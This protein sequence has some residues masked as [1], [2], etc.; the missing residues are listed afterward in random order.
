MDGERQSEVHSD[1]ELSVH[2]S[3]DV[4][5][6]VEYETYDVDEEIQFR[7][8]VRLDE[9]SDEDCDADCDNRC[10]EF[11]EARM[12]KSLNSRGS[13][14]YEGGNIQVPTE[15]QEDVLQQCV[16]NESVVNSGRL[17]AHR[18]LSAPSE[19][20]SAPMHTWT[21]NRLLAPCRSNQSAPSR[22]INSP[23]PEEVLQELDSV[24]LLNGAS[25]VR[26]ERARPSS[27]RR[28][29]P[30]STGNTAV[31]K[32]GKI[33]SVTDET[34]QLR[35]ASQIPRISKNTRT[36]Q[37]LD[38]NHYRFQSD[39]GSTRNMNSG[40]CYGVENERT[41]RVC[42]QSASSQV[43]E[44]GQRYRRPVQP[45]LEEDIA[46]SDTL[47]TREFLGNTMHQSIRE[48][49][50]YRH[51]Y[52]GHEGDRSGDRDHLEEGCKSTLFE[53]VS[54]REIPS[55]K[56]VHL[57][58]ETDRSERLIHGSHFLESTSRL[59]FREI[60]CSGNEH[61]GHGVGE[62]RNWSRDE[63]TER[64]RPVSSYGLER[65]CS[66]FTVPNQENRRHVVVPLRHKEEIHSRYVP[67]VRLESY[68]GDSCL[69]TFL[70]KFSNMASY[71]RWGEED[72]LFHLRASLDGAAAQILWD[73]GS[74]TSVHG[75]IDL[76]RARFGNE[77]QAERFRAELKARRRRKGESLQAL[78]NEICRLLALAYP[79]P[80]S[81]IISLVG[82]DAFL[83]AL[84][85]PSLK[86]RILEKEPKTLEEALSLA[87]RL[88][89]Y[90]R[91][92]NTTET[93]EIEAEYQHRRNR[94]VRTVAAT[95]PSTSTS[96]TELA[97]RDLTK[98]MSDL[99][100]VF[101]NTGLST[102]NN[103]IKPIPEVLSP[104]IGRT[105]APGNFWNQSS[106]SQMNAPALLH[107]ASAPCL[108]GLIPTSDQNANDQSFRV[109]FSPNG[110]PEL[111]TSNGQI[112][113]SRGKNRD[114]RCYRCGQN[115]HWKRECP[116]KKASPNQSD[117]DNARMGVIS[118]QIRPAEIYV[119]ARVEGKDVVCLLDTG[120][121]RSLIGRKL[122][123]E[124]LLNMT[125]TSLFAANGTPIPVIGSLCLEFY[126]DG[127]KVT[128]D[129]LV[130]EVLEEL[131][132]GID[133]LSSNRCQW[134][135][136]AAKLQLGENEIRVRKRAAREIVRRV[137][138]AENHI[139]P[140]GHQEDMRV[141]VTWN[142][143]NTPLTD[144]V[145]EPK[146]FRHGVVVARTLLENNGSSARVR[147]INYSDSD[148]RFVSDQCIGKA[149]PVLTIN[150]GN[151]AEQGFRRSPAKSFPHNTPLIGGNSGSEVHDVNASR[152]VDSLQTMSTEA[153]NLHGNNGSNE[154]ELSHMQ[155][156]FD[157]LPPELA[158]EER[159]QAIDFIQRNASLFSKSEFDI[160][161]TNLVQ[162]RIDTGDSHPFRQA[163]RRHP[164]AHLPIIDEHVSN[165]L[166]NDI[167][168]PA[169]SAWASNVVL[170]QK[171]DGAYVSA[172]TTGNSTN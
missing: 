35:D 67:N 93:S 112:P 3:P 165:M 156:I 79:G 71:L 68:R 164:I 109:S 110:S 50:D 101:V 34:D 119:N 42:C 63:N 133:W 96:T 121:E 108:T 64:N 149:E 120:C 39:N 172:S 48:I 130:T 29:E 88:E 10:L 98:Q 51:K 171:K 37:L 62:I 107:N 129:L 65:G 77:N 132:L 15:N 74:Q 113:V 12:P 152:E 43:R 134:D 143:L 18:Q 83:D 28:S 59:P 100:K 81:T 123:P 167:V 17:S 75:I 82:R 168:E 91:T 76:L 1:C 22:E 104:L 126:I 78:Y 147:V 23:L 16:W 85:Q 47:S 44:G 46:C 41:C 169:A 131:I 117:V 161:R 105:S 162:H 138:V 66:A 115:G 125:N 141:K 73:T 11:T 92:V 127:I 116:K 154:N 49:P 56:H 97:L 20:E 95:S 53:P 8:R 137:Y 7:R 114:N 30:L 145:I 86:L 153:T 9:K 72:Q 139:L 21:S 103:S 94:H 89:A 157:A 155:C 27:F 58:H 69:E 140:A 61:M 32:K 150:S 80:P 136:G 99:C 160:G 36:K 148:H 159:Q 26:N 135:L 24:R 111:P 70:A 84:D 25:P 2:A 52:L 144:W 106:A 55:R 151:D 146:T 45:S 124:R 31:V 166:A 14:L 118:A 158:S 90:D 128:A 170:I 142:R 13:G 60:P 4:A 40:G 33:F 19:H 38:A 57:G 5:L 6:D 122:V 163:L 54:D 87:S 102:A